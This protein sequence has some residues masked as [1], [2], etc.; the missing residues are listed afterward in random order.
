MAR[1]VYFEHVAAKTCGSNAQN[2][3]V[4]ATVFGTVLNIECERFQRSY[5]L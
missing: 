4:V 3:T 1:E 2:D 5:V